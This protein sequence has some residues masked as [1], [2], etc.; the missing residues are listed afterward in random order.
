[1]PDEKSA[2][3]PL[4]PLELEVTFAPRG[5]GDAVTVVTT[6][7]EWARADE[8]LDAMV[9]SGDSQHSDGWL[10]DKMLGAIYLLAAMDNRLMTAGPVTLGRIFDMRNRYEVTEAAPDGPAGADPA[11][12]TGGGEGA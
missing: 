11:N 10:T 1:M 8:W 2:G 5:G 7:S 6:P 3:S 12:P 4:G 9:C